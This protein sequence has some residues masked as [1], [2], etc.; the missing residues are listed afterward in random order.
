MVDTEAWHVPNLP[1][2]VS[3][4]ICV[5][6]FQI[7]VIVLTRTVPSTTVW[8]PASSLTTLLFLT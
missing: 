6:M 2:G 8:L 7:S 3:P 4:T 1:N 5:E